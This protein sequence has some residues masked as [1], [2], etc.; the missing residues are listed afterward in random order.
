M[1]LRRSHLGIYPDVEEGRVDP[2][3]PNAVSDRPPT[4]KFTFTIMIK[5]DFT[6][7]EDVQG[8]FFN[9]SALKMTKCQSLRKF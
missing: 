1:L 8:G 7:N 6:D 3:L 5:G 4:E 2:L 9:W